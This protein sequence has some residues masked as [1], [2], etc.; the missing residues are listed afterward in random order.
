VTVEEFSIY[1]FILGQSTQTLGNN[2]CGR[3]VSNYL[4]NLERCVTK[5]CAALY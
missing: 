2:Y 4:M 3:I 1:G 5:Y